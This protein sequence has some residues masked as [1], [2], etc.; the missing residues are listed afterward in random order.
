MRYS[1]PRLAFTFVLLVTPL[2]AAEEKSS[3]EAPE[4]PGPP[5]LFSDAKTGETKIGGFGGPSLLGTSVNGEFAVLSGLEGGVLIGR[6]V[7][8]GLAGYGLISEVNGPRFLNGNES[9]F[10]LGYGGF[11]ARYQFFTQSPIYGSVGG[12]IGPGGLTLVE[13]IS[14][15]EYEYD[16]ENPHGSVF[17]VV[18][19]SVQ[20]HAALTRWMRVGLHASYRFAHGID[21]Y[22][23]DDSAVRGFSA[24][25][26]LQFGWF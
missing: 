10:A 9:V 12:L 25:G 18:E 20:V 21:V 7:S 5:T 4:D 14:D 17:L 19:P 22:G 23:M 2:A 26:N 8:L 16:E 24:G 11:M 1:L 13:K 3:E 15:T 6:S